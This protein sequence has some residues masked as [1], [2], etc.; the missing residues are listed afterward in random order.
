[1]NPSRNTTLVRFLAIPLLALGTPLHA[2]TITTSAQAEADLPFG[3][4]SCNM[5]SSGAPVQCS[6]VSAP[7]SAGSSASAS[8]NLSEIQ[9]SASVGQVGGSASAMASATYDE[10]LFEV[11]G[12]VG[13]GILI[14]SYT[15]S[16]FVG[17]EGSINVNIVQGDARFHYGFPSARTLGQAVILSSDFTYGVPFELTES[18]QASANV[19]PDSQALVQGEIQLQSFT[20]AVPESGSF[21]IFVFLTCTCALWWVGARFSG[22]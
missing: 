10:P 5:T 12:G 3:L 7:R 22:C 17:G 1:M 13:Q 18:V 14:G 16:T 6:L 15:V 20:V 11:D 2:A 4:G 9:A 21:P 19:P 8:G